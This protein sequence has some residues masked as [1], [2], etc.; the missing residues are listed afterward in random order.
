MPFPESAKVD[1][2]TG[3][4]WCTCAMGMF[5]DGARRV[6]SQPHRFAYDTVRGVVDRMPRSERI[7]AYRY[8]WFMVEYPQYAFGVRQA[9]QL[10]ADLGLP[11][12]TV[13]E[14][15]VAGGRGLVAL[16]RHAEY[17][18]RQFG[19]D[20]HVAGFDTGSGLPV[21]KDYR[22]MP[23]WWGRGYFAMDEAALR[24]SLDRAELVLGDLADTVTSYQPRAP[25]GF[26]S[27]DVDYYSSASNALGLLEGRD[28]ARWLP[29][30]HCYFDDMTTIEWVG[31]RRAIADWN[32]AHD[33]RKMGARMGLRDEVPGYP[34]WADRCLEAHLFE[35]PN[36][37]QLLTERGELAL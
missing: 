17:W 2:S 20:I 9:G 21:P 1:D 15:G 10:A 31:E 11:A 37:S 7:D 32:A 29:R 23:Y 33:D 35:H 28:W 27:F 19:I 30:V 34:V 16:E 6:L 13:V 26:I 12:M 14:C 18:S 36:Y 5:G 22:D 4:T 24:A 25:I 3:P 8:R